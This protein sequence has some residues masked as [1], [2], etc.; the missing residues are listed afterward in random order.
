[1]E[2]P[3]SELEELFDTYLKIQAGITANLE[4][5]ALALG[6]N[7]SQLLVVRDIQDHPGTSL[8]DVCQRCGLKKSA[9][10]RLIDHLCD[11]EIVVRQTCPTSRRSVSL[12]LGDA[13]NTQF[14]RESALRAA[15]PGLG[16]LLPHEVGPLQSSLL[17]FL[18]LLDAS[19]QP[20]A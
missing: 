6:L 16:L 18:R 2:V 14:C 7:A 9:V 13:W 10:S 11:R 19:R 8:K 5:H 15:L 4:A 17:S 12:S 20:K 3:V 1:M